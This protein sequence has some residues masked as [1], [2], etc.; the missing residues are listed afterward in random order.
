MTEGVALEYTNYNKKGKV[1]GVSS[2]KVTETNT[3]GNTTNA[4]MAII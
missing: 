3:S 4:T 1:E 2:F